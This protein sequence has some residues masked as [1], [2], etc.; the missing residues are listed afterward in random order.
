MKQRQLGQQGLR[1]SEIGMGTMGMSMA[2]GPTDDRQ[3]IETI[4]AGFELGVTMFDTAEYYGLGTGH[5]EALLGE[6]VQ[7]FR[8]EVVLATKFGYDMTK[9]QFLGEALDSRPDRIREVVENSLRFLKTDRIDLLYQHRVDPA[10]PIE[11]VAGAVGELVREGKVL[12]FGLSEA[13]PELIRR[14]H[15]VHPLSVLQ[16]E[17]SILERE[18]ELEVLPTIRELG[19]GFVAYAPLGRGFLTGQAKP[20]SEYPE[21]DMRRFDPR[22]QPENFAANFAATERLK[23]L[24]TSKETGVTQ[25]ALAWLLAQGDDIVPIPGT[26]DIQRLTQNVTAAEISLSEGDLAIVRKILPHGASGSRYLDAHMPAWTR[27]SAVK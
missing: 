9:D 18:I 14:A 4:R 25:L 19:I 8:D 21:G 15:A 3:S 27:S 23:E 17:Y 26:R 5:N 1:V 11:E 20:A 13:S 22:W 7:P 16:S 12:F 2:Y 6:A 24:A 10:V